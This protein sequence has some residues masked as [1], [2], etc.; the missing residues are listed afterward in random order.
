MINLILDIFEMLFG[1]K[2]ELPE[3]GIIVEKYTY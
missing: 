3:V 1:K 2:S